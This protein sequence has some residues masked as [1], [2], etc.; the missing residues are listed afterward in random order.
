MHDVFSL[1]Y[2]I[3]IISIF[4]ALL[5]ERRDPAETMAWMLIIMLLPAIGILAYIL[6][7][8]S[9]RKSHEFSHKG[10]I[11]PQNLKEICQQ[12][13]HEI[14]KPEY[15]ELLLKN[16][17]TLLL[18]NGDAALTINNR[19]K[20]LNNG[21]EFFPAFF[22]DLEN[23]KKFIHI[24]V[25]GLESGELFENLL[26]ILTKKV[27]E[28]V[29]V[30][31]IYDCVGSR[32][33]KHRDAKRMQ[34]ADIHA[35]SYMPVWLPH[36][37]NKFNYRNHRK[38]FVIDG[39]IG[40]TGGMNIADRY[41]HGTERGIWRDT[42]I[43]VQGGAVTMLNA[44]FI[45]DWSFVSNGEFLYAPKYFPTIEISD[46]LPIQIATSGPDSPY[47]TIMQAY[48]AAIGKAK[49]YIYISTPYLLPNQPIITA[50]KV[51]ALSGVD[52]RILI[53]VRGDNIMVAWA[54]YSNIDTL[55]DAGVKIYMYKKGFNH[56]KYF[57][58]DDEFCSIGSANLDYRSFDIDFEVQAIIYDKHS[59][60]KLKGFFMEDACESELI[61]Q[62]NWK[63]RPRISKIMEPIA[64]LFGRLF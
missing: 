42:Q 43:R 14:S 33:L 54:G 18:N 5:K 3:L 7:G 49:R 50:L 24:E 51:A 13:L 6:F 40:Y 52:V 44:V 28:G 32:A 57:V 2:A 39:T 16:Y 25:F 11:V 31:V 15:S 55:I 56:S 64:R 27:S 34:K 45:N 26:E 53:P 8:R 61:T 41:L 12:Q 9:W 17:V 37:A 60:E 10:S 59:A 19:L 4:Y 36:F 29:E 48:F 30:R 23:A 47:A 58:M 63:N 21:D 62:E 38:I 35:Y 20:I 22:K 1:I 46:V